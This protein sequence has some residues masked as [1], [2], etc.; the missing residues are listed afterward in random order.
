MASAFNRMDAAADSKSEGRAPHIV[1]FSGGT[2]CRTIN[3]SLSRRGYR[4]TRIVPA[5]D[6]GGSS[7][8][9][10]EAFAMIPVGDIRQALM[11]M[12]H[13]EGRVGEVVRVCNARFSDDLSQA[14]LL[15]ELDY[16]VSGRHPLIARMPD[17]VREAILG[18]LR[19]FAE[20]AGPDFDLRN[21]SVGNFVLTGAYIA[22]ERDIDR[23]IAVFR[24]L[25]GIDGNVWP[26]S[27]SDD[28]ELR[29][30][31][32]DGRWLNSQ[33]LLTRLDARDALIGIADIALARAGAPEAPQQNPVALQAIAEAD[34]I[35]LGP[36]SFYTSILPH[37][38]VEGAAA[39]IR[40]NRRAPKVFI[41]NILEDAETNGATL[42]GLLE[43]LLAH[44]GQAEPSPVTH[45]LGNRE[46]FPFEKKV[47]RVAYMRAGALQDLCDRR[48]I[49]NETGDLEDAWTRGQHDGDA[50]AD[51]L[52]AILRQG[53]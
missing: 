20:H 48:G 15:S 4:L 14:E 6:S 10:R 33:H 13:G 12:A 35:V 3:L 47:G 51:M 36:G 24:A 23:A 41:G 30:V 39:A 1:L 9:L 26:A 8:I 49:V 27:I 19:I 31:L 50:V 2:A 44:L 43:I 53:A 5:W 16:Y 52:G 32:N 37:L 40:A 34:M 45:V 17:A 25:C 42:A 18:Y 11:T 28:V 21:G 29:G 46:L 38:L 22:H 7:K